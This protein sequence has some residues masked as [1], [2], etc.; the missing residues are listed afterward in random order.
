MQHSQ[1]G[2]KDVWKAW[3][4]EGQ[5]RVEH[6]GRGLG[7]HSRR[8]RYLGS[9]VDVV[10][11]SLLALQQCDMRDVLHR[12]GQSQKDLALLGRFKNHSSSSNYSKIHRYS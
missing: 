12:I 8:V 9:A 10:R 5:M 2:L 3:S 4:V 6:L 1:Q 11:V 7:S